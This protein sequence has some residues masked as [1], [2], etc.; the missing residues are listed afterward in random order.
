MPMSQT[1]QNEP[2]FTDDDLLRDYTV[3]PDPVEIPLPDGR[4][5]LFTALPNTNARKELNKRI[6]RFITEIP[7]V[8]DKGH[9]KH[10]IAKFPNITAA[11]VRLSVEIH[12]RSIKPRIKPEVAF[13]LHSAPTVLEHIKNRLNIADKELTT[14][15]WLHQYEIAQGKTMTSGNDEGLAPA[16]EPSQG[17][18]PTN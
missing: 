13:G 5:M 3:S 10:F 15:Y 9:S 17:E 11:E 12:L 18:T 16:S 6:D 8:E 1:T 4:M 7:G 14:V 2:A